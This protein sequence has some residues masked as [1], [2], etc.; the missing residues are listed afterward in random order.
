MNKNKKTKAIKKFKDSKA[1]ENN[2]YIYFSIIFFFDKKFQNSPENQPPPLFIAAISTFS[3]AI[4]FL[5]KNEKNV[6][7]S[8]SQYTF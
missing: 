6:I 1:E 2:V 5:S 8:K 3:H 7:F 4:R